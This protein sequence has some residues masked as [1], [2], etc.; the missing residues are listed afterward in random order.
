MSYRRHRRTP[1]W[2]RHPAAW[3]DAPVTA[4]ELLAEVRSCRQVSRG[5]Y[6]TDANRSK[7]TVPVCSTTD[8]VFWKADMDIDCDG[9][10][11]KACNT[12]TDPYFQPQT[13]F[14]TSRGKPLDS[15]RCRTWWCRRRGGSGTTGSPG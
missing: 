14:Q 15:P 2:V 8:A 4:E 9:R 5:K 3:A 13:A 7:A 6:R 10:K 12:G 1:G 11:T